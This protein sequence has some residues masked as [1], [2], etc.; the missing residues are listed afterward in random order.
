MGTKEIRNKQMCVLLTPSLYENF[1][2]V[3][4]TQSVSMN[5]MINNLIEEYV[6]NHKEL[7]DA[8]DSVFAN[9]QKQQAKK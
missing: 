8:Y 1:K 6:N 5:H 7:I 3:M 4:F 2:K 9:V